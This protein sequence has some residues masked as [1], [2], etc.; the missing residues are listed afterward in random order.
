MVGDVGET[1]EKK[2]E[3]EWG[4]KDASRHDTQLTFWL[5]LS[6]LM[7]DPVKVEEVDFWDERQ[8]SKDR[9]EVTIIGPMCKFVLWEKTGGSNF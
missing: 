7:T 6:V 3:K 8:D 5:L 2:T 9:L 1:L 4:D